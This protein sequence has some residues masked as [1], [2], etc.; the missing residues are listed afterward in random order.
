MKGKQRVFNKN[1][2]RNLLN[3]L[4]NIAKKHTLANIS[5]PSKLHSSI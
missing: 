2:D 4:D 5:H 3:I 1:N